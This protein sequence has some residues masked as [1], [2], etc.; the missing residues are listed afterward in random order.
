MTHVSSK[1][2]NAAL[3]SGNAPFLCPNSCELTAFFL[4]ARAG[5][6]TDCEPPRA[7]NANPNARTTQPAT[8]N[9]NFTKTR[10]NLHQTRVGVH[11]LEKYKIYYKVNNFTT[12]SSEFCRGTDDVMVWTGKNRKPIRFPTPKYGRGR[13]RETH[14]VTHARNNRLR[15]K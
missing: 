12:S 8:R 2:T 6:L 11:K 4:R 5:T 9:H 15:Y 1:S 10:R 13:R 7:V 14:Y 3:R